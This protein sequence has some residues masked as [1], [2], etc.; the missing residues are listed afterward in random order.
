MPGIIGCTGYFVCILRVQ[1]TRAWRGTTRSRAIYGCCYC[2]EVCRASCISVDAGK[3]SSCSGT[4]AAVSRAVLL[5]GQR[6]G[7]VDLT[8]AVIRSI[9]LI[10]PSTAGIRFWWET[11][12]TERGKC[13]RIIET[14]WRRSKSSF[15]RSCVRAHEDVD[16]HSQHGYACSG[17]CSDYIPGRL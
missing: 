8:T 11:T 16:K 2:P 12:R 13:E 15:G 6:R 4:T 17:I 3:H 14:S 5:I 9:L 1:D 10:S 7:M